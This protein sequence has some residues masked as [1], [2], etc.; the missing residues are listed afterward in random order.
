[1]VFTALIGIFQVSL[2]IMTLQTNADYDKTEERVKYYI[3][4]FQAASFVER[5]FSRNIVKEDAGAYFIKTFRHQILKSKYLNNNNL[6]TTAKDLRNNQ[7]KL[8]DTLYDKNQHNRTPRSIP[9]H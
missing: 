5:L 9:S 4:I 7:K 1:M 6:L 2:V 3:I 8:I